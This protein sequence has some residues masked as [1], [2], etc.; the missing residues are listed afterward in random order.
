MPCIFEL[1]W[2]GKCKKPT[3]GDSQFCKEHIDLHCDSCGAQATRTCDETGQFVCGFL[4]CNDCDHLTFPDGTNGGV[5][6]NQAPLP[7]GFTKRHV[8]KTDQK[9]EPWYTQLPPQ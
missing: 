8:K 7:E 9:F 5:G 1:A 3:Q 6:F 4:L 2:V